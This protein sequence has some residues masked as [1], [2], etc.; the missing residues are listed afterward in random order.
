VGH[1]EEGG[2]ALKEHQRWNPSCRFAKGLC[3][4]NIPILSNDKP[5]KSSDQSTRSRYVCGPRVELRPNS[6]VEGTPT[7]SFVNSSL[8][9][10]HSLPASLAAASR[11]KVHVMDFLEFL[12][13][14]YLPNCSI[15]RL[16]ED[17]N[18]NVGQGVWYDTFQVQNTKWLRFVNYIIT[19]VNSD[20]VVRLIWS[21]PSYVAGILNC[22]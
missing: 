11:E 8:V 6:C 7:V 1:W 19:T 5:K 17:L 15:G 21:A 16:C 18:N 22:I 4:G 3:V 10:S 13:V 20:S 2:D 9:L 12:N 14:S